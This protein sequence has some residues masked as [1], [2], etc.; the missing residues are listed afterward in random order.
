MA[1]SGLLLVARDAD[2]YKALQRQFADHTITKVYKALIAADAASK[3]P[4][5]GVITLPLRPDIDDRPRQLVDLRHGRN[6]ITLYKSTGLTLTTTDGIEA[7]ELEL[8][9]L[10]GRTHQLRMHC[11]HAA[12]LNSPIIGDPLYGSGGSR[13]CLHAY[14]LKFIHPHT[15][16][17]MEFTSPTPW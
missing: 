13:L 4:A 3:L 15:G 12:G 11:A 9:P 8:R 6:A 7:A 14:S 5:E 10:T 16:Q 17:L 2:T 1:T